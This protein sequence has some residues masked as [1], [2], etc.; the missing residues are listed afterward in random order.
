MRTAE[1]GTLCINLHMHEVLPLVRSLTNFVI[2]FPQLQKV[3]VPVLKEYLK[4]VG[5]KAAGKKAELI[6]AVKDHLGL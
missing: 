4:S 1:V 5:Q 3:T 6:A 2:V